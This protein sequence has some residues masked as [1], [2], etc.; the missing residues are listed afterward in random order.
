MINGNKSEGISRIEKTGDNAPHKKSLAPE[1]VKILMLTIK[2]HSVG[3]S[4]QA[5]NAPSFAP[6]MNE[7][8]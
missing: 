4:L 5:L 1:D 7:A 2:A 8:K 3:S 6:S